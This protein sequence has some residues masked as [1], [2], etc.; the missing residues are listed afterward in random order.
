MKKF[1]VIG[2][3]KTGQAVVTALGESNIHAI[4]SRANPL[5]K[6]ALQ[7]ASAA[8]IFVPAE[9]LTEILPV[10]I[11]SK[12]PVVCGTTG[13]NWPANFSETLEKSGITWIA[14]SNFSPGMNFLFSIGRL[15]E[16]NRAFLGNP[17]VHLHEIHHVHKKDSP[18]GTALYLNR[19][20]GGKNEI[21]A[22]R[23]GDH[24]GLH[25]IVVS[26][27]LETLSLKHEAID[28]KAF[29][30]G[31]VYAAK[32]LLPNSKPGFHSFEELMEKQILRKES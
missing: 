19:V 25:E 28:R 9:A 21:K 30:E 14:G 4:F 6:E 1:A 5:T 16:K 12:I 24:P 32:S 8:I 10:L 27:G 22:E 31:A 20:L 11:E 15:L 3:G 23:I 18:S 29:A 7:G 26:N 2:K 17:T 13:F